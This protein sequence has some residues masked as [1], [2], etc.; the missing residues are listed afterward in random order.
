MSTSILV[1]YDRERGIGFN[2]ELPWEK[3]IPGDL[4]RFR[5]LTLGHSV[6]MGRSTF[7]SIGKPLPGREN[8]ILSRQEDL[9][10]DDCFVVHSM[11]RALE[12]ASSREVDIIG[13]ASVY[14]EGLKF[15]DTIHATEVDAVFA[16]DTHFPMTGNDWVE[17]ERNTHLSDE[18]NKYNFDFVTYARTR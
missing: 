3:D 1:A 18:K 6:V 11:S 12:I 16:T 17:T 7:E 13:G 14:Q 8:I 15:A 9:R 4:K 5:A 2:G 10:I